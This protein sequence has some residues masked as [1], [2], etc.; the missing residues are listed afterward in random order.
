MSGNSGQNNKRVYYKWL[1][2]TKTVLAAA[3]LF[4]PATALHGEGFAELGA[5]LKTLAMAFDTVGR[6]V[7]KSANKDSYIAMLQDKQQDSLVGIII[8]LFTAEAVELLRSFMQRGFDN[9]TG[10]L[11]CTCR[12][13]FVYGWRA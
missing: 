10:F 3:S 9:K 13:D 5:V 6:D 12:T 4:M 7:L 11:L 2:S 8:T 1:V